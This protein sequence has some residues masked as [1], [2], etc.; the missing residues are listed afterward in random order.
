MGKKPA[1]APLYDRIGRVAL[2]WFGDPL[3]D[4][5]GPDPGISILGLCRADLRLCWYR[6]DLLL[7]LRPFTQ[8]AVI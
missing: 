8:Q 1:T 4:G 7:S 3:P 2:N 5:N 6:F